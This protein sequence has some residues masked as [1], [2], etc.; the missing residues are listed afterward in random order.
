M[1]NEM[2][3]DMTRER[4]ERIAVMRLGRPWFSDSRMIINQGE[5]VVNVRAL[6]A[7]SHLN[8]IELLRPPVMLRLRLAGRPDRNKIVPQSTGDK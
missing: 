5:M 4:A 7:L 2:I 1:I 6:W 3:G 8:L